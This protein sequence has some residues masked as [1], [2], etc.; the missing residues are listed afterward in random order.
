E[1]IPALKPKRQ[2][3]RVPMLRAAAMFCLAM[4]PAT[5]LS[6]GALRFCYRD[7]FYLREMLA[8]NGPLT[9]EQAERVD[10][11]CSDTLNQGYASTD[12][13]SLLMRVLTKMDRKD[14]LSQVARLIAPR[15]RGNLDLQLALAQALDNTKDYDEAESEYQRLLERANDE[16]LPPA[17]KRNL[18]LGAAR[19]SAHAGKVERAGQRF[20]ELLRLVP[21]D[22][23]LRNECAGVYLSAD[24]PRDALALFS[25]VEPDLDGRL[26]LVAIN[27][28]L[29][30]YDAAEDQARRVLA[31]RPG[32]PDAERLLADVLSWKKGFAQSRAIYERLARVRGSS[33]DL[34][35]RLAQVALWSKN[36][37]E[38][39][40]RF[41]ALIDRKGDSPEIMQGYVDAASS[42]EKLDD[43]Q[44]R[45]A[46]MLHDR[47]LTATTKDAVLLARLAWVLQRVNEHEKAAAL[48]DRA[49][50]MKP[51][52]PA[53]RKQL[54]GALVTAGRL[55]EALDGLDPE[56]MDLD[57]RR[58]LVGLHLKNK[59]NV[60]AAAECR[61]ILKETP[62]DLKTERLLADIL[63]WN[64]QYKESLA[65]FEGLR[66]KLPD[67]AEIPL[68]IAEVTMWAGEVD[69]P[70]VLLLFQTL[71]EKDFY[72]TAAQHGFVD[73][74]GRVEKLTGPQSRLALRICE[75]VRARDVKDVPF[76][77]RLA[78][79]LHLEKQKE[80]ADHLLD[81]ALALRP[82]EPEARKELA[83]VLVAV[84][85]NDAALDLY[86][87]LKLT[88]EDRYRL[89]G[90][91]SSAKNYEAA[92]TT[93]RD[94]LKEKPADPKVRRL[95]ADVLSWDRKYEESQAL[96]DRLVEEN[97]DDAAL[98]IRQAEVALWS[99]KHD[100][101]LTL[102]RRMLERRFDQ[103]K[104]WPDY[105]NSA[106]ASSALTDS[107]GRLATRIAEK[108]SRDNNE[109]LALLTRLAWVL[110][111]L[112]EVV[113]ARALLD[114]V[115]ARKPDDPA[116]RKE[117]AGVLSAAGQ[118]KEALAQYDGL[119]LAVED[120]YQL[121]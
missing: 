113:R 6:L 112:K 25:G 70:L 79:V 66:K 51:S 64:K 54:F 76:L 121:A 1:L 83:G 18:L 3:R 86:R 7:D 114:Q 28:R 31:L 85:R 37:D 88:L 44:K 52:D 111:R 89:A 61:R 75:G 36:Y 21:D 98:S 63:S 29:E 2:P 40:A 100:Q 11:I 27:A 77:T 71:L 5:A 93:C 72:Q 13:L 50:A 109:D 87:G 56:R 78:W 107:D 68:R 41:Q 45:T 24:R 4:L 49:V 38:A 102:F 69:P 106:S 118:H 55:T 84:G 43:S 80:K 108:L 17:R 103:P 39:L 90:L 47:L 74:A 14:E 42:A 20:D 110:T 8:E 81:A 116:L 48:L 96:F 91:Y 62:S 92:A 33:P 16:S 58:F 104:L 15:D 105:V 26:L 30:N 57:T 12:R 117:L 101:A 99:G 60:A 23:S 95:L 35:L 73:A 97:P 22:S 32:D 94:I 34:D 9:P 82:Q 53:L 46:L 19:S 67:D 65:I 115:V 119:P 10:R 120:R 59:N